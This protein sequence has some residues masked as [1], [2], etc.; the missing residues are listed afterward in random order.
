MSNQLTKSFIKEVVRL[1]E[2]EEGVSSTSYICPTGHPTIG[3]GYKLDEKEIEHE[4]TS[5][6]PYRVSHRMARTMLKG[7]LVDLHLELTAR[8]QM[9]SRLST[10][11]DTDMARKAIVMSMAY[12]MGVQG[13][14]DFE[15]TREYGRK[16]LW[17]LMASEMLDSKWYR[18]DTQ[19]RAIAH[20]RV[21]AS[22]DIGQNYE[23]RA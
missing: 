11:L 8:C 15:N 6:L 7:V 16:G 10:S 19:E 14:L 3:Y 20:S 13:Y 2:F 12:Q 23:G 18:E 21:I 4:A 22:G 9:Y 1:L 5:E 17:A